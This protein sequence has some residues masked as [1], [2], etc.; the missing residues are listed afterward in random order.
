MQNM[1]GRIT[2]ESH[3][4]ADN[5]TYT[6]SVN[7]QDKDG[8]NNTKT[9]KITVANVAPVVAGQFDQSSDEGQNKSFDLGSFTDKGVNDGPWPVDVNWGDGSSDTTFSS[10]SQGALGTKSHT[11]ADNGSYTVTVSVTDKD[12]GTG[13]AQFT[14]TVANLAPQV[15]AAADQTAT[16]GTSKSFSL[17]SF[18]DAGVNDN[19]WGV[20]VNWG[21]GSPHTTFSTGSQG[22]LGTQDHT[23]ADNGTY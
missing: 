1:Q 11:Y 4:Y 12:G 3:T 18:S 23:Y 16:E 19:P 5:G 17:G 20:D 21:D 15:A 14:V 6:V 2:A 13:T 9:F 10:T 7:V 8:G 22:S